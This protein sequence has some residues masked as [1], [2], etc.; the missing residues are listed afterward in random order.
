MKEYNSIKIGDTANLKFTI[1]QSD[2]DKYVDLTGDNNKPHVN[3]E[4]A[5]TTSFKQTLVQVKSKWASI[6][7]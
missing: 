7:F 2:I 1:A 6:C 5:S 4:Y 3:K